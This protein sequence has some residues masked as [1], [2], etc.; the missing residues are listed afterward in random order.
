MS[1]PP[2]GTSLDSVLTS[3]QIISS[4]IL[5]TLALIERFLLKISRQLSE[6][7][8]C[9]N[10]YFYLVHRC[11]VKKINFFPRDWHRHC[12]VIK[13]QF[14]AMQIAFCSSHLN[15]HCQNWAQ[16]A[17]IDFPSRGVL[18]WGFVYEEIRIMCIQLLRLLQI[19][20]IW[21]ERKECENFLLYWQN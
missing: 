13:M 17:A 2:L 18:S 9:F 20:W 14:F 10:I 6:T 19:R 1:C 12:H 11:T 5:K 4:N 21:K 15:I 3:S 16:M 8:A 7:W